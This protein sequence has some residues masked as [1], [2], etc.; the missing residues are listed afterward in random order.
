MSFALLKTAFDTI[1]NGATGQNNNSNTLCAIWQ[2]IVTQNAYRTRMKQN[3]KYI[4]HIR[5]LLMLGAFS[6]DEE[7]GLNFF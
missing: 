7:M 5:I 1:R 2:Q 4:F 6:A 3:L